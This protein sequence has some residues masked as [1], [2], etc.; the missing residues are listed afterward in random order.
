MNLFSKFYEFSLGE[1]NSEN[2]TYTNLILFIIFTLLAI[3]GYMGIIS[4]NFKPLYSFYWRYTLISL[5][6]FLSLFLNLKL[7]KYIISIFLIT[8]FI[9]FMMYIMRY[10]GHSKDITQLIIA[11]FILLSTYSYILFILLPLAIIAYIFSFIYTISLNKWIQDFQKINKIT[12]IFFILIVC[13]FIAK[14]LSYNTFNNKIHIPQTNNTRIDTIQTIYKTTLLERIA[15]LIYSTNTTVD[16]NR[17][18]KIKLHKDIFK[19]EK[20]KLYH[21]Y[22]NKISIE[23]NE[24]T[25]KVTF[26]QIPSSQVCIKWHQFCSASTYGF[27]RYAINNKIFDYGTSI[28]QQELKSVAKTCYQKPVNDITFIASIKEIKDSDIAFKHSSI[29]KVFDILISDENIT[30]GTE[31]EYIDKEGRTHFIYQNIDFLDGN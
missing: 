17:I 16:I 5:F 18:T 24:S 28:T 31:L 1:N 13:L 30:I 11:S 8:F 27:N 19:F 26:H 15:Y 3:S 2:N 21:G 4:E 9:L 25:L 22:G 23:Q 29:P 6:F 20:G 7:I 12:I 14:F 10:M